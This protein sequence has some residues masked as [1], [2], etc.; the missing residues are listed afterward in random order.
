MAATLE[1]S[2][3]MTKVILISI[4]LDYMV[5][6]A[7][8][9]GHCDWLNSE[10]EILML[11]HSNVYT[12]SHLFENVFLYII[13]ILSISFHHNFTT[14]TNIAFFVQS[15][16]HPYHY[17]HLKHD[18]IMEKSTDGFLTSSV[19]KKEKQALLLMCL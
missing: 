10:L 17:F 2:V 12:L 1:A 15:L 11:L 4:N 16:I 8:E 18:L 9:E 13:Y 7:T 3:L 6:I 5:L 14:I 19:N